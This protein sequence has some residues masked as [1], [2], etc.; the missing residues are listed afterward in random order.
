[1]SAVRCAVRG[2]TTSAC[3]RAEL[4]VGS[5]ALRVIASVVAAMPYVLEELESAES[6][7]VVEL[8]LLSAGRRHAM[9][10]PRKEPAR[11]P[12]WR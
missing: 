9:Y 1:M 10:D 5:R 3:S 2:F 7:R 8:S 12:Y 6:Q 11:Y 4:S